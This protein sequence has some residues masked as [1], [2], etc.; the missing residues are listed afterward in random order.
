MALILS[1]ETSTKVC[2]VA[3]HRDGE[4]L[5]NQTHQIE[6]SHSSLLPGIGLNICQ[7]VD[8]KFAD[9]DA[10]AIS[11]GPGSYTGLRIGV[12]TAKGICYSLNKKLISVPSLSIMREA[13]RGKFAGDHLLCPMMDARRME[14]YT[15]LEDQNGEIV[16]GLQPKILEESSFEKFTLPLYMFGDGMPKFREIARQ[17]NLIFIDDIFPDA[18]NMGRLALD[19]FLNNDFEDVAYF[20]P[21]Y[22]KEW[23]TTTPKKQLL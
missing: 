1:I 22:L 13:L 4:L 5:A 16:W 3:L 21:N 12:S 23:R 7:E 20:E 11:S 14:V 6:K 8:I 19:K 2:S 17:D 10:V 18:M 9:L 15:Q